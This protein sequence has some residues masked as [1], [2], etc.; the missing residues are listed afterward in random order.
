MTRTGQLNKRATF[1]EPIKADD[2]GGGHDHSWSAGFTV[3]AHF[4]P[5]QGRERL[6]AGRLESAYMAILTIRDSVQ[7]RT[8]T[9]SHKVIVDGKDHQ[10]KTITNPD[11]HNR[12]IEMLVERGVGV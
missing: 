11:Q 12:F 10:I 7:A 8:I 2:T 6:E 3:W 4:M 5:E 1:Q 9:T